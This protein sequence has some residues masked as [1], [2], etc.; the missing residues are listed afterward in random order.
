MNS[1]NRAVQRELDG[2]YRDRGRG[3]AQK[4]A[5]AFGALSAAFMAQCAREQELARALGDEETA[6]REQVK[7]GVMAAAREMFAAAYAGA[8]GRREV[9]WDE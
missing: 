7:A 1:H 3:E 4:L 8:T 5:A 6:V 9:L 2:I